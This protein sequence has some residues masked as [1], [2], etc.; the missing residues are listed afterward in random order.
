M[1]NITYQKNSKTILLDIFTF[2]LCKGWKMN[3]EMVT[4]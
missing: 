2:F 3:T 1:F 4:F